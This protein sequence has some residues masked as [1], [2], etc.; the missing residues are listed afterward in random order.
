[1]VF[2]FDR[3]HLEKLD[4]GGWS[5]VSYQITKRNLALK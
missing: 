1:M 3:L 2:P 5:G 4:R